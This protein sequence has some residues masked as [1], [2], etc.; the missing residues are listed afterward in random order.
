VTGS[1]GPYSRLSLQPY[2]AGPS[3]LPAA[4]KGIA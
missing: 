1:V 3:K 2:P 4:R